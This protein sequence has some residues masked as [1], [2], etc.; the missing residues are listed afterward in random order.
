[1]RDRAL[2]ALFSEELGAVLQIRAADRQRVM[3]I[4]RGEGVHAQASLIGFLND[5]DEIRFTRNAKNVFA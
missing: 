3:D 5:K 4:L 2:A 1:M